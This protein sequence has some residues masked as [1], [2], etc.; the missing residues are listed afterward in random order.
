M[1]KKLDFNLGWQIKVWPLC[2]LRPWQRLLQW[3]GEPTMFQFST[4]RLESYPDL[5]GGNSN[6]FYFHPEPW[7]ND[8]FHL[9]NIFQMGWFNHQL[10]I[11]CLWF[12]I[13]VF[14]PKWKVGRVTVWYFFS[15]SGRSWILQWPV[16]MPLAS[17]LLNP[18]WDDNHF[19]V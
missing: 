5:D 9:A 11:T 4:L 6:M 12:M 19:V 7:G 8:L 13:A 2:F 18:I 14:F 3:V 17:D 16:K 15:V 1:R 10:V